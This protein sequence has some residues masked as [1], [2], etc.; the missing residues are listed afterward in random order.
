MAARGGPPGVLLVSRRVAHSAVAKKVASR[1]RVQIVSEGAADFVLHSARIAFSIFELDNNISE[2]NFE[3]LIDQLCD[4]R[5]KFERRCVRVAHSL[6][7]AR[8]LTPHAPA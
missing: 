5:D 6:L 8:S 3:A 4:M 1:F 7:R 2:R